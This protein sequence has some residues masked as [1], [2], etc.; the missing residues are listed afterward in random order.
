M[1]MLQVLRK[2]AKPGVIEIDRMTRS[3]HVHIDLITEYG[4]EAGNVVRQ[5]VRKAPPQKLKISTNF[6]PNDVTRVASE[7][8]ATCNLLPETRRKDLERL[9]LKYLKTADLDG[10]VTTAVSLDNIEEY[11]ELLYETPDDKHEAAMSIFNLIRQDPSNGECIANHPVLV[12]A[13]SQVLKLDGRSHIALSSAIIHI[14]FLL[15]NDEAC[16]PVLVEHRVAEAALRV[17]GMQRE[18]YKKHVTRVGEAEAK[19]RATE[20]KVLKAKSSK[21]RTE[22]EAR[23]VTHTKA[24]DSDRQRLLI[25][26]K[27]QDRMFFAAF[28]TLLNLSRDPAI[29]KS[30]QQKSLVQHLCFL[31][32]RRSPEL[33]ILAVNYLKNLSIYSDNLEDMRQSNLVPILCRYV[34]EAGATQEPALLVP[35]LRLLFNLS[36]DPGFRQQMTQTGIVL[37]LTS[38]LCQCAEREREREA[39]GDQMDEDDEGEASLSL[40]VT[41]LLYHLSME[42]ETL[43]LIAY[44]DAPK[45]VLTFLRPDHP[46]Y[47]EAVALTI[48]LVHVRRVSAQ[49]LLDASLL[50]GLLSTLLTTR[51]SLLAKVLKVIASHGPTVWGVC[52]GDRV[53]TVTERISTANRR[54]NPSSASASRASSHAPPSSPIPQNRDRERERERGGK[55]SLR[56]RSMSMRERTREREREPVLVGVVNEILGF[57]VSCDESDLV[58]ELLG[59]LSEM[60]P[61][62]ASEGYIT[63]ALR[64][65]DV[66]AYLS[67]LL[68]SPSVPDDILFE[69]TVLVGGILSDKQAAP[70]V[71]DSSIPLSLLELL[72]EKSR[73]GAG[74]D[75]SF[76]VQL[77]H[78]LYKMTGHASL[79]GVLLQQV[80]VSLLITVVYRH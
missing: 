26:T 9:L 56:N 17:I 33:I 43:G 74:L 35:T 77:L 25:L 13:L 22:Y 15:S 71:I 53:D 27:K 23:V 49:I 72:R 18:L 73:E 24:Y 60:P 54:S 44:S 75:A 38:M 28:H 41:R 47:T 65:H 4:D 42:Q 48:N 68:G 20:A 2:R 78:T 45:C 11:V 19:L 16:H 31:L 36:F 66:V 70:L 5:E 1:S 63:P 52:L 32:T 3:V 67:E 30:L 55:S 39:M 57:L 59:T 76:C 8:I 7:L 62:F 6:G 64:R 51:D 58:L 10:C 21:K 69:C 80:T 14:F 29:E 46:A 79:R 40:Y 50:A 34:P 12:G 61:Q 37:R